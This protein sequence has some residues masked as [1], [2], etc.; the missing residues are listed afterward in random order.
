MQ[1][2]AAT[3]SSEPSK[4][5]AFFALQAQREPAFFSPS[6]LQMPEAVQRKCTTCD[7]PDPKLQRQVDTGQEDPLQMKAEMPIV[8]RKCSACGSEDKLQRQGD[9]ADEEIP[10]S[11][12]E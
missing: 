10:Q 9:S 6:D 1:A 7:Q 5:P 11:K 8:Q 2:Q 12:S 3:K 4:P